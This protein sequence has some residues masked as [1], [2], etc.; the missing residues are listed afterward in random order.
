MAQVTNPRL[1]PFPI[2]FTGEIGLNANQVGT[3]ESVTQNFPNVQAA[4]TGYADQLNTLSNSIFNSG[5]AFVRFNDGF[6]IDRNNIAQFEDRNILYTARND[7]PF[8]SATRPDVNLPNDT[9]IQAAGETYPV[10]FEFT[11]LGGTGVFTDRNV[12]RLFLDGVEL[13][14]FFRD[15]AALVVKPAAGEDYQITTGAF[16]PGDALLPNGV[17]NLKTDTPIDDIDDIATEL[18]GVTI[19]GG[20][21]FRVIQGG[22]WSGYNV[23]NNSVL[24]ALVDSASTADSASNNDWLYLDNSRF[25]SSSALFFANVNQVGNKFFPNRNIQVHASNVQELSTMASGV[26]LSFPITASSQQGT[27]RNILNSNQPLQ[28]AD[29]TGGQLTLNI[30]INT[31]SSSGFLPEWQTISLNYGAGEFIFSFDI[32][33]AP[34][35]GVFTQTITIPNNDYSSIFN[36]NPSVLISFLF[37]G[38]SYQG[39]VTITSLVNTS[40]GTL[41]QPITNL[42]NNTV[43]AAEARIQSQV[44]ALRGEVNQG[45]DSFEAILGRIS[46]LRTRTIETPDGNARFLASTGAD[47]FP[48]DVG[49]MT[50]VAPQNPRFT[51]TT[52]AVFVAVQ[53][54]GSNYA[55]RNITQDTL[56]A[57]VDTEATVE[58]GASRS[59]NNI[60]YFVYR[61]TG[62][63]VSDVVEVERLSN[64]QVVAWQEDI[65]TLESDISRIDAE[66]AHA[67]LDLPDDVVQVLENEVTV[68]EESTPTTT[69]SAYNNSLGSGGTQKIYFEA[70]PNTVSGGTLN[71]DAFSDTPV[72]ARERRKLLYVSDNHSYGNAD[73]VTAFDG[74]ATSTPLVRYQGGELQ[75]YV[76]VPAVPAGSQ[77]VTVYPAQAT[78]VSHIG[79]QPIWQTL[80]TIVFIEKIPQPEANELFFTRDIP[81]VSTTLTIQY[82]GHA[83]GNIFSPGSTTL[84]GVGGSSNRSTSFTISDGSET[85]TVGVD[86]FAST[87][88]IRVTVTERVN[89]GLPTINDVQVILSYSETRSVPAV[90]A[91]TRNVT[92]GFQDSIGDDLVLAFKPSSTGNLIIV[93]DYSEVDTGYAYT[94]LFGASE[95]GHINV[96][97]EHAV[98]F[99]YQDIDIINTLVRQLEN[100]ATLPQYGLFTTS[101]TRETVLAM[102]VTLRPSGF[103]INDLPTSSTGLASGDVWFDGA[104]FQF[105]P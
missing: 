33:N 4:L 89:T 61:V 3:I 23:S 10:V 35:N 9:E 68:T 2:A 63:A 16:L 98:F 12:V 83:N 91:T 36:T 41:H 19:V 52:T 45:D 84:D 72:A 18:S 104:A 49:T 46:P 82:R 54:D 26:P 71:S 65:N 55:L 8:D 34:Q 38:A 57:L 40:V 58:L 85:A 30:S 37:R 66:L 81:S 93:S 13:R 90:P 95:G 67:V 73:I 92:L 43:V 100:R 11:H 78:R 80:E 103:N 21:A 15:Q 74:T 17:F 75:A 5:R 50:E 94:T 7:K 88:R 42:I 29:L 53:A 51:N 102:G 60:V 86:Y 59:L 105:V 99:D 14:R 70:S 47:T 22:S 101:Y 28:V 31:Q 27:N 1:I 96:A 77:P 76:F 97:S 24:I 44:D 39:S 87:R 56:V 20:D 79:D 32:R 48:A 25:N 69:P 62:L 6:T 64:V